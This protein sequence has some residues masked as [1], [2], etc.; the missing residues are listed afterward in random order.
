[1]VKVQRLFLRYHLVLLLTAD[2]MPSSV[3]LEVSQHYYLLGFHATS[4]CGLIESIRLGSFYSNFGLGGSGRLCL[5]HL[6]FISIIII[7]LF[8]GLYN[9]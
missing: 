4:V 6:F 2:L 5:G 9:Q 3:L 1:M 8:N 7:N